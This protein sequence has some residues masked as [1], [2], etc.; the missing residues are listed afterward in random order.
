MLS[1]M[2]SLNSILLA[3]LLV[4]TLLLSEAWGLDQQ[5]TAADKDAKQISARQHVEETSAEM[6]NL[7]ARSREKLK[8]QLAVFD[9]QALHGG[10]LPQSLDE[11]VPKYFSQVPI[12][13]ATNRPF[14]MIVNN[15][16]YSLESGST[17]AEAPK[18]KPPANTP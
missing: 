10:K 9:Y 8:V 5:A 17:E 7:D 13:P 1:A 12:D 15:G 3:V 4:F 14:V 16:K 6:D 2:R 11:L 18:S